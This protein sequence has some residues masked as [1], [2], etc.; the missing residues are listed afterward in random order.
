MWKKKVG[1]LRLQAIRIRNTRPQFL[2]C[3]VEVETVKHHTQ[4]QKRSG[5]WVAWEGLQIDFCIRV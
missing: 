3:T 5:D 1:I 4:K 2:V